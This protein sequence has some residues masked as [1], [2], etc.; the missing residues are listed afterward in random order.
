[1]SEPEYAPLYN[2]RERIRIALMYLFFALVLAIAGYF[3]IIPWLTDFINTMHCKEFYGVHGVVVMIYAL[4]VG[5]PLL[6]MLTMQPV[7]SVHAVKIIRDAQSPP[8]NTKVFRKTKITK[9]KKARLTGW[10]LLLSLPVAFIA[11]IAWGYLS[12]GKWIQTI[13]VNTLD[14]SVCVEEVNRSQGL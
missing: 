14:Y 5:L 3:Y 1:M 11:I 10:F 13:D 2:R 8:K 6:V 12:A 7:L 4:F 9:G